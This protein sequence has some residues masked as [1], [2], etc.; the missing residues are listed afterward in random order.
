MYSTWCFQIAS[1]FYSYILPKDQSCSEV[2]FVSLVN[3]FAKLMF[4][5]EQGYCLQDRN[6]TGTKHLSN[7]KIKILQY[8]YLGIGNIQSP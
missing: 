3:L 7:A 4:L 6:F 8:Q 2:L 1:F 5:H